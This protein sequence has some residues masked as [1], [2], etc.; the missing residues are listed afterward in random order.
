MAVGEPVAYPLAG[1]TATCKYNSNLAVHFTAT[2]ITANSVAMPFPGSLHKWCKFGRG[3]TRAKKGTVVLQPVWALQALLHCKLD[4]EHNW[5]MLITRALSDKYPECQFMQ[6][7]MR[8]G[9]ARH[10]AYSNGAG[11]GPGLAAAL[12]AVSGAP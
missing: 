12:P 7:S 8:A 6:N 1:E 10:G 4:L 11:G 3:P 2:T 5:R 9:V